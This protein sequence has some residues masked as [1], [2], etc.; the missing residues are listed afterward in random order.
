MMNPKIHYEY[1][2]KP[3]EVHDESRNPLE[4]L[5]EPIRSS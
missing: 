1:L 4:I 2:M 5:D 3:L